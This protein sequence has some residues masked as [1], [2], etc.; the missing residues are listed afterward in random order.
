[1]LKLKLFFNNNNLGEDREEMWGKVILYYLLIPSF[2]L[3]SVDNG[4]YYI[5]GRMEIKID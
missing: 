4:N 2:I 3:D 1:M 5:G